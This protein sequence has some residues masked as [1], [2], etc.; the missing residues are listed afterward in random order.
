MTKIVNSTQYVRTI[1]GKMRTENKKESLF[2]KREQK[3]HVTAPL[4]PDLTSPPTGHVQPECS[5]GDAVAAVS[6]RLHPPQVVHRVHLE[7]VRV[8]DAQT[9]TVVIREHHRLQHVTVKVHPQR[10]RNTGRVGVRRG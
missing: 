7:R 1:P 2:Q 8:H 4:A 5:D 6:P 10:C 3:H 9:V